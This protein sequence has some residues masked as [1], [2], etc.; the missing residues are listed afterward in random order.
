MKILNIDNIKFWQGG[1]T[2]LH[3]WWDF[4]M[5]HFGRQ[6][7]GSLKKLNVA[8]SYDSAIMP[9]GIYLKC[10]KAS[11]HT[12]TSPFSVSVSIT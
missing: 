2:L 5:I 12:K 4:K 6:F 10:L 11:V 8:L 7:G 9:L 3:G 1:E